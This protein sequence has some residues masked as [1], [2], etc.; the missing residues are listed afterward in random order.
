MCEKKEAKK[1]KTFWGFRGSCKKS[2][3]LVGSEE[4]KFKKGKYKKK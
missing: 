1:C 2:N 3:K 4:Y